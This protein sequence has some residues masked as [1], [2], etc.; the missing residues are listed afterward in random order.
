MVSREV[1][2]QCASAVVR[3]S[4]WRSRRLLERPGSAR[5]LR[6]QRQELAMALLVTSASGANGAG[7]GKLLAFDE[8][9]HALG[10]FSDDDRIV[11]PRGVGVKGALLF[12]NSGSHR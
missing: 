11:D 3:E 10:P 6:L 9:G 2:S 1:S 4:R 5:G 8:G 12:L 7:Y